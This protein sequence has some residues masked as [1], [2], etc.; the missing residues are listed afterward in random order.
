MFTSS[1]KAKLLAT[2]V[3]LAATAG[4]ASAD[5]GKGLRWGDLAFS[6]GSRGQTAGTVRSYSAPPTLGYAPAASPA[7]VGAAA[8]AATSTASP[9]TIAI[10]G[11]DGVV[12]TFPIAGGAVQQVPTQ[13]YVIVR[14]PNGVTTTYP[15]ANTPPAA[16]N[17]AVLPPL[18][19]LPP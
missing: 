16:N 5:P 2:F 11:A 13:G 14:N 15:V 19:P 17:P 12:R 1:A 8:T 3:A 9:A 6:S 4:T 18:P 7:R 10:R